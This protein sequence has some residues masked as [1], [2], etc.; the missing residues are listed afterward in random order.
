MN[1][2]RQMHRRWVGSLLSFLLP[3][4]GI[5]LAGDRK[6]GL[7]WFFGLTLL[8]LIAAILTPLQTIPHLLAYGFWVVLTVTLA[9]WLL[10]CSYR[11]VPKLGLRGWCIFLLLSFAFSS[12]MPT[13]MRRFTQPFK[14]PASSM[15][16]TINRDDHLFVQKYAY[17]FA[18]PKRGDLVVFKTEDIV[19]ALLPKGQYYIKRV[20]ALPGEEL[21]IVNGRLVVGGKP[22]ESPAALAGD[23]FTPHSFGSSDSEVHHFSVP[24]DSYFVVGDNGANSFD[25]RYFGSVSRRSIIGKGT[26]IYWPPQ[27]QGDIR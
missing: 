1:E 22:I 19:H 8:W 6:T 14:V 24:A 3:G 10:V 4:A 20:A 7:R 26:K 27:R 16:P 9:C 23:N 11:P 17:W 12:L 25:S 15:Q 21:E 13:V 18:K 2:L 5:Y